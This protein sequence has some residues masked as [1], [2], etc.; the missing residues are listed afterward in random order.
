MI[1]MTIEINLSG[2]QG[3]CERRIEGGVWVLSGRGG[4][5]IGGGGVRGVGRGEGFGC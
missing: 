3:G 5:L 1:N 2:D 4:G